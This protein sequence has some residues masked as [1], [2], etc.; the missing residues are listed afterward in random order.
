M[1]QE[2]HA[3]IKDLENRGIIKRVTT[4]TNWISSMLTVKKP[5][6]LR[7]CI[8][9]RD[10]NT[11]I[12]RSHYLMPTLEDM[13]PNLANAKVFSVLDAK[14]GF[15]HIKLDE[16][17]CFLTT[18]WTPFGRYRWLRMPFGLSS[19]PEE[20]QRRQ[21]EVLEGLSGAECVMDDI[22]V[23]GCGD[24]MET[25]ILDHDADLIAV[26]QRARAVGLKLNKDKFRLRQ[27]EVKYMGSI[28]T[29]EGICPDPDKV[30]Q[31]TI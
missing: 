2:I 12:K 24:N 6:K 5:G 21:H 13:L 9:P 27:T 10:L 8:D 22:I 18:F 31:S 28:L 4:P 19:A 25:A 26:L 16:S 23:F 20:F 15:W 3:K 17:S 29:A 30:T 7:I 1:K 14:E 11:A